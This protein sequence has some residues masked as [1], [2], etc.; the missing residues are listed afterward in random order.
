MTQISL[1]QPTLKSFSVPVLL[2][3]KPGEMVVSS[4]V[5]TIRLRVEICEILGWIYLYELLKN[6]FISNTSFVF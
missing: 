1:P 3:L 2:I 6:V 5:G 4:P